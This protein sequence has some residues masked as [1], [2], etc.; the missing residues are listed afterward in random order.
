MNGLELITA[1]ALGLGL[2]AAVGF[3]IVVP[4]LL[5]A[6]AARL[7]HLP[8]ADGFAWLESDAALLVFGL[9]AALEV[10]AYFIPFF[11]HLLD[12]ASQPAATIAGAVLMAA[13]L[14]DLP[15]WVQWPVAVIVGGGTA[16]LIQGA[17]GALR[18]GS[19]MTTAGFANPL[20]SFFET[21]AA[22]VL[23][24]VAIAVPLV[25][26]ALVV[27]LVVRSMRVLNRWR[28]RRRGPAITP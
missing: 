25:A 12:V 18:V 26:L 20:F 13:T 8:L 4:L 5:A 28:A 17:T 7:G 24:L 21:G 14:I 16:G 27:W 6:L 3:R 9:A 23:A 1:L 2:A 22:T 15:A 11:D 10:A 19:T